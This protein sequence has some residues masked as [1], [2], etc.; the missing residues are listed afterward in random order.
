VL[1]NDRYGMERIY[2]HE[3]R[4]QLF[5]A[6]EAKA[7][8]GILPE[9]RTFDDEGLIDFLTFGCTRHGRTL[10]RGVHLLPP[11][12]IWRFA[13]GRCD[14][15]QYF[16]AAIWSRQ[17]PM[18]AESFERRFHETFRRVLPRYMDSD[19]DV[20]ISLTGG[21]DTRMI[22]ACRRDSAPS[23][24]SYTFAGAEGETLDV[25]LARRVAAA[26]GVPHEVIRL[27][28]EWF[29][30]FADFAD[31]TVF[32]TDGCVGVCGA[33]EIHLNRQARDIAPLRLTG[34]YGSEVLRGMT[35]FKPLG[36]SSELFHSDLQTHR[37]QASE[38]PSRMKEHPVWRAAFEE[39]PWALFG[40]ARAAQ[41]QVR[42]RTPYL[43]NDLVALA[44]EAPDAARRSPRTAMRL[45]SEES[46]ALGHIPT[47]R[48]Q[49]PASPGASIVRSIL[50][51]GSFK[52]DYWL[53]EGTPDWFAPLDRRLYRSGV[54]P[55]WL[56][57][58][59][60]LHYRRWFQVELADYVRQQLADPRVVQ[61]GLWSTSFLDRLAERHIS[62]L[63]N[64]T[65][66]IN[67]VL[68]I[69]AIERLLFRQVDGHD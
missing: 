10:F 65:G 48:G 62:G 54:Y 41:S 68:T 1:F 4:S 59:K 46:P 69:A 29:R 3:G 56:H 39:A 31:R 64:H 53:N 57:K 25:Q 13:D 15:R 52:I 50:Y 32:L 5:F 36:L 12:S 40:I 24:V 2:Y 66:E 34:N 14:R 35:T 37:A 8:L 17:P 51:R 23:L 55:A 42:I 63:R 6:S 11:A 67:L 18:S 16:D 45:I 33:H 60:Y 43:D 61:S 20:G 27:S 19:G 26:S 7:L 47:D 28:K 21:L 22:M 9:L 44:F 58:H 30:R 38:D 49:L